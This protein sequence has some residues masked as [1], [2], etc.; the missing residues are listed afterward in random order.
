M[1]LGL[2]FNHPKTWG[3]A[4][5]KKGAEQWCQ[6]EITPTTKT[7]TVITT[8][9]TTTNNNDPKKNDEKGT[10]CLRRRNFMTLVSRI[11]AKSGDQSRD[12]SQ[13]NHVTA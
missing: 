3:D 5:F 2:F 8:T 6:F 12:R 4:D 11:G 7:T 13:G 9:T 10:K 1:W